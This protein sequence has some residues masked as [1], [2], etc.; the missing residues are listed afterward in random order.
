MR[1]TTW[2]KLILASLLILVNLGGCA[3]SVRT[4][5]VLALNL[6]LSSIDRLKSPEAVLVINQIIF[7]QKPYKLLVVGFYKHPV[8]LYI[9]TRRSDAAEVLKQIEA[10]IAEQSAPGDGTD[11]ASALDLIQANCPTNCPLK[12][13]V[14]TDGFNEDYPWSEVEAGLKRL[15]DRKSLTFVALGVSQRYFDQTE[16]VTVLNQWQL[17]LEKA[18]AINWRRN[19]RAT[20]SFYLDSTMALPAELMT[21]G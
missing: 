17:A 13:F 9:D 14:L 20:N 1:A 21:G 16:R 11:H 18:G 12:V 4:Q 10:A 8:L 3:P 5:N 15:C 7:R 19:R 2:A 6:S